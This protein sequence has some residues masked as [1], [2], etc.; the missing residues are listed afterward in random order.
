MLI[1][2]PFLTSASF[3]SHIHSWYCVTLSKLHYG[4]TTL[5]LKYRK[6]A[7]GYDSELVH[8]PII[9]FCI[10]I[11]VF[12]GVFSAIA[13]SELHSCPCNHD[14]VILTVIVQLSSA[15]GQYTMALKHC[16]IIII[17]TIFIKN[18]FR[19]ILH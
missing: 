2:T 7:I 13:P 4:K 5:K 3:P 14:S 1:L 19:S 9:K 18:N 12:Q 17:I 15:E 10:F 11:S 8:I 16:Y 6:C